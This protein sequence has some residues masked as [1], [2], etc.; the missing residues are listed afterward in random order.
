MLPFLIRRG[1]GGDISG[2]GFGF[3]VVVLLPVEFLPSEGMV[4]VIESQDY[5]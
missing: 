1:T 2:T 4:A 5:P 3:R